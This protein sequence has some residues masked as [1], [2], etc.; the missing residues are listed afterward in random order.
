MIA[1]FCIPGPPQGKER[2]RFTRSG[3]AYTPPKTKEYEALVRS[4]WQQQSGVRFP[5]GV[6]VKA[7]VK[8]FFQIPQSLSKKR[9]SLLM[10]APHTKKCDIDNLLKAVFDSLN[11]YAYADDSSVYSVVAE[12]HYS[13]SPRVEVVL[14]AETHE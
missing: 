13:D 6:P 12:K 14:E 8:A 4:C 10:G 7:T 3:Y 1:A 2:P 11:T 9:R 5:D